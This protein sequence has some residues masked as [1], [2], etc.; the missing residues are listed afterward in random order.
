VA[1]GKNQ[2]VPLARHVPK[3]MLLA[4]H[5]TKTHKS[6]NKHNKNFLQGQKSIGILLSSTN[7]NED[8]SFGSDFANC[9]AEGFLLL[10]NYAFSIGTELL[11]SILFRQNG[12]QKPTGITKTLQA[13]DT[14]SGC[15]KTTPCSRPFSYS[16]RG[17]GHSFGC[18]HPQLIA[19]TGFL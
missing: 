18:T 3:H 17:K 19:D 16:Q 11:S 5:K 10:F 4:E 2:N 15:A 7:K 12:S 1:I 9:Q 8:P 13:A 14:N 6:L